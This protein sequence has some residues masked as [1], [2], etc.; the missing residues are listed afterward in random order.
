MSQYLFFRETALQWFP[1]PMSQLHTLTENTPSEGRLK[2]NI[3]DIADRAIVRN[4]FIVAY[5]SPV[6]NPYDDVDISHRGYL[7]IWLRANYGSYTREQMISGDDDMIRQWFG[8][9][10]SGDVGRIERL[11]ER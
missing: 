10:A 3:I 11:I 7:T 1:L 5:E 6:E 8:E 9:C 4:E 2:E